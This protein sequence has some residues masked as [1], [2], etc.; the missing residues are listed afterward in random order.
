MRSDAA[1]FMYGCPLHHVGTYDVTDANLSKAT[2]HWMKKRTR[3]TKG[4]E[5]RDMH[6]VSQL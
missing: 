3:T 1:H 2:A 5:A 4:L 6:S